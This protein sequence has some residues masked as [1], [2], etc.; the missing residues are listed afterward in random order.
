MS[1]NRQLAASLAARNE[2]QAREEHL[3]HANRLRGL[4]VWA[5]RKRPGAVRLS[6]DVGANLTAR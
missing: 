5:I 6:P 3:G 2:P 1:P 4:R